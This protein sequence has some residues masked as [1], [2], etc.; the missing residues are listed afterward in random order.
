M[1][2][3]KSN[4][5]QKLHNTRSATKKSPLDKTVKQVIGNINATNK[6]F[7]KLLNDGSPSQKEIREQQKREAKR[8]EEAEKAQ[9]NGQQLEQNIVV[10][11]YGE[12]SKNQNA[13]DTAA[14]ETGDTDMQDY[15]GDFTFVTKPSKFT[16]VTLADNFSARHNV[17]K[18]HTVDKICAK[19]QGYLGSS[20]YIHK[21]T[22]YVQVFFDNSESLETLMQKIFTK[23]EDETFKFVDLASVKQTPTSQELDLENAKTIQVIDIPLGVKTP[24]IRSTFERYGNITRLTTQTRGMYQHAFITYE[25]QKDVQPFFDSIW[26]VFILK[27]CVR[28]LPKTLSQQARDLRREHCVKISGLPNGTT[29][30]DLQHILRETKA[31]SCFIPRK[32]NNYNYCNYAFLTFTNDNMLQNAL[33]HTYAIKTYELFWTLPDAKTCHVCGS[34][35]HLVKDC[36]RKQQQTE[37][38][39]RDKQL[40]KLYNR[41]RP[42]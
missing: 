5:H 15:D 38:S 21:R 8:I 1:T 4:A 14:P 3:K 28:V 36:P 34:P 20:I 37:R 18:R 40:E 41:Y 22:N 16:A 25:T 19:M 42:A 6:N 9:L 7:E 13:K 39:S 11:T 35:D 33:T 2:A 29:A 24:V 10:D 27:D 12:G 30:H 17:S 26:S 31:K 23:S 32:R